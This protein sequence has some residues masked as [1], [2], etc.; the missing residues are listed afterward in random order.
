MSTRRSAILILLLLGSFL[1]AGLGPSYAAGLLVQEGAPTGQRAL[2]VALGVGSH[3]PWLGLA[4][5]ITLRSDEYAREQALHAMGVGLGLTILAL[6]LFDFLAL[7]GFIDWT[8]APA[9]W[10]TAILCWGLG[11]VVVRLRRALRR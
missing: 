9:P 4:A 10:Q 2:A 1:L 6:A 5:L 11:F 3:L 7:A 8:T